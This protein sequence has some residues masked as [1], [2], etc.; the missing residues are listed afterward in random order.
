MGFGFSK[1]K[2]EST[3][4]IVTRM[5]RSCVPLCQVY[6]KLVAADGD[7]RWHMVFYYYY[8]EQLSRSY[9]AE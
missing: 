3:G 8:L 5:A 1:V 9:R 6:E 2:R 7:G 4:K